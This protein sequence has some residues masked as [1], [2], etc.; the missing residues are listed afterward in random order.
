MVIVAVILSDQF[1]PLISLPELGLFHRLDNLILNTLSHSSDVCNLVNLVSTMKKNLSILL[2]TLLGTQV[3]LFNLARPVI[4]Q[5]SE[6]NRLF[7]VC[8]NGVINGWDRC[9]TDSGDRY[10]GFLRNGV[11]HGRGIFV[12]DNNNRYEGEWRNGVPNGQGRFVFTDDSRYEGTWENGKI[13]FGSVFYTDGSRYQGEFA[14][15]RRIEVETGPAT[16]TDTNPLGQRITRNEENA[17]IDV[18]E[19]LS[20][21]PQ[22]RGSLVFQNGNRYEGD[23]FAGHPYGQGTFTF[24]TGDRC[25]GFFL[26]RE[27]DANNATCT[28]NNGARYRGELRQ[29][30]PHGIGTMFLTDGTTFEGAFRDGQ[31]VS[32]SG[33]N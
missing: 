17:V 29:A 31:P 1:L 12:Y 3:S 27:F 22:G 21:Q 4:A 28:Y 23:F 25:Q 6:E 5:D 13:V 20:R 7:L 9:T 24:S 19:I 33:Y 26:N 16:V 2:L 18:R 10:A 14:D 30:R 15:V 32:F 8:E 11:P